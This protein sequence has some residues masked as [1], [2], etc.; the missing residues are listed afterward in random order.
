MYLSRCG[1][2]VLI[3]VDIYLCY[4]AAS[5]LGDTVCGNLAGCEAAV[6]NY[7]SNKANHAI[8]DNGYP[9]DFP[10]VWDWLIE[11][12]TLVR[13]YYN[14]GGNNWVVNTGWL[15]SRIHCDWD[16][17]TCSSSDRVTGLALE[18]NH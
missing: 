12:T 16:G 6:C 9:T 3:D 14:D 5:A 8:F 4:F 10:G 11:R 1:D 13:I 15:E 17:V 7:M 2:N 18:N